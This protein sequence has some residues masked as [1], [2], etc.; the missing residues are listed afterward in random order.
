MAGGAR[1]L[2][3][4]EAVSDGFVVEIVYPIYLL[5]C[6]PLSRIISCKQQPSFYLAD[7]H[8][9]TILG[10][11]QCRVRLLVASLFFQF[12][13]LHSGESRTTRLWRASPSLQVP[14]LFKHLS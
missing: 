14:L 4:L 2:T 6:L 3:F 8:T 12:S 9:V 5:S 7:H 11:Q 10:K 13:Q 1:Q